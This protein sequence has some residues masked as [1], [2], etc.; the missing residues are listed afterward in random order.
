MYALIERQLFAPSRSVFPKWRVASGESSFGRPA[1]FAASVVLASLALPIPVIVGRDAAL[2]ALLK[3]KDE[4]DR[5]PLDARFD[6]ET[7]KLLAE[8]PG[9][10]LDV[11]GT[12]AELESAAVR[13]SETIRAACD[14]KL[15]HLV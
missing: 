7:K 3:L 9:F 10:Y 14:R 11:Y 13:G 2:A 15:P 12:L 8:Q 1:L 5:P 4:V 6:L